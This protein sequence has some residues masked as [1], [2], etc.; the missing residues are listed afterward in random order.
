M[1][2]ITLSLAVMLTAASCNFGFGSGPKAEQEIQLTWWKPF[3]EPRQV[4]P[5]IEEFQKAY[6][7]VR[8]NYV[9]KDID[10]Y[11][12]ELINAL[13]SGTGPDIFS[14]HNDWLPKHKE[15]LAAAPEKLISIR[16]YQNDFAAAV[17]EDFINDYKIYG[18]PLAIDVLALYYNKNI[19]ASAGIARPPAT[20]EELV[21]MVPK[22]TRQD[23]LGN[24]Q[25]Q[26]IALGTADNINRAP[27]ILALLML[28]NGT[29]LYSTDKNEAAFDQTIED[30]NGDP[31]QPGARAL[32]FYTQFANPAKTT[33]TWNNRSNN[34]I[35][36]FAA[37]QVGMIFSYSYL[38]Q[39]LAE[40]APFLNYGIVVWYKR[41]AVDWF[42]MEKLRMEEEAQSDGFW[43]KLTRYFLRAIRPVA[44]VG[45]SIVDPTY[46]FIYL[47]GRRQGSR[48]T[49]ND[50][51]WFI[52]SNLI[53]VLVWVALVS[54]VL[55]VVTK[56][57]DHLF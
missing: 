31:Y 49:K 22:L 42:G 52:L 53:G 8:V 29:P 40:K 5:L 10:T 33:Y 32:E 18:V 30:E 56:S 11:E 38:R 20:W 48:F 37:G 12:E 34:S 21:D 24:F 45:L 54:G 47:Q 7:K 27:D 9:K 35:E 25:R 2:I 41:T 28:Q 1:K 50:W 57:F 13:A 26:A 46:G 44:Y 51:A 19:L 3:D 43:G 39:T 17:A 16:D 23:N 14:I 6:P 15:K 4:E 36:A 55:R